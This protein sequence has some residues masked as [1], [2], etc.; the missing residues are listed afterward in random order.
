LIQ[1][2]AAQP[3]W[4]MGPIK[5]IDVYTKRVFVSYCTESMD[6]WRG[7]RGWIGGGRGDVVAVNRI[8]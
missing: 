3:W 7:R 1:L 4:K 6:A 2:R 5:M 8:L